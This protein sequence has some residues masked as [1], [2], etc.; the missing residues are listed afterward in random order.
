MFGLF[1]NIQRRELPCINFMS[2]SEWNHLDNRP[3]SDLNCYRA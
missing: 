3:A 2:E 1:E